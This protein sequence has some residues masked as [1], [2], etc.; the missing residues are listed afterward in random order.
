MPRRQETASGAYRLIPWTP[1]AIALALIVS[2]MPARAE[3]LYVTAVIGVLASLAVGRTSGAPAAGSLQTRVWTFVKGW[4]IV[5]VL[6]ALSVLHGKWEPMVF[7]AF[8]GL[9][10]TLCFWLASKSSH[11]NV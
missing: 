2:M 5:V 6:A 9:V 3:W 8:V 1:Y 10:S 11:R 4:L 7:F